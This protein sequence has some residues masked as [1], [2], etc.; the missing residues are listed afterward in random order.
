[1]KIKNFKLKI[2]LLLFSAFCFSLLVFSFTF[3]VFSLK[4]ASAETMRNDWYILKMGNFNMAAGKPT[5][6]GGKVSFTM[7]QIGS[8]LYTGANYKVRAGFQYIYTLYPFSFTISQTSIDFGT[9][10]PANPVIR[11][12]ILTVNNQSA[13]GYVVTGSENH[14]MLMPSSGSMIPDTTCDNGL[15]SPSNATAWTSSLTY[16][17]G[18]RC[19]NVSGTDCVAAFATPTFY[20]PFSASPTATIVMTGINV[21]INK[22]SQITYKVNVSNMQPG[23]AYSNLVTYIAT[24]TF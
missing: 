2:P 24:P 5:G 7:G 19:D 11:T 14:P 6:A 3:L 4:P 1:M 16:G 8:G 12:N 17:F 9:I 10:S 13:G 23:G 15:C 22:Q 21:G 18:Y 20:K